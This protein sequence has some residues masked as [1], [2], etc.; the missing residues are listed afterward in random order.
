MSLFNFQGKAEIKHFNA[1]KEGPDEDKTLALDLKLTAK[2]GSA[3]LVFFDEQLESFLYLPGTGAVRNQMMEPLKYK[4]EVQDC[5]LVIAGCRFHG[6]RVSKFQIEPLDGNQL[7]LTWQCS[8]QPMKDECATLAELLQ[9]EVDVYVAAQPDLFGAEESA[10]SVT[11]TTA[12]TEGGGQDDPL[13]DEAC[14]SVMQ[15]GRASISSVQRQLRIGYNRA[16]R[17]IEGME[18]VGIV[19]PMQ[20]NGSREVLT[21]R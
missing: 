5:E 13:F 19:S 2:T 4:H 8:F 7:W 9:E 1:R 12:L 15:S 10:P 20:S 11:F 3:A 14:K 16:A 6:V 18:Q 21:T 17:L